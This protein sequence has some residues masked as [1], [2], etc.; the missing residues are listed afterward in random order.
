MK[1]VSYAGGKTAFGKAWRYLGKFCE[2]AFY[3][4]LDPEDTQLLDQVL[5][6]MQFQGPWGAK[7]SF[8]TLSV[9]IIAKYP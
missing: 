9:W 5:D 3:N 2:S 7:K 6:G 1:T 4:D 8:F